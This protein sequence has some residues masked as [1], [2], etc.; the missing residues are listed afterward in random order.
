MDMIPFDPDRPVYCVGGGP[1]LD[2]FNFSMLEDKQV[3]V[4]N[5][6]YRTVKHAH[7]LFFMDQSFY[8][9]HGNSLWRFQGKHIVTTLPL[10]ELA[11]RHRDP[12]IVSIAPSTKTI[13][14]SSNSGLHAIYLAIMLQARDII[15]MGYD[16]GYSPQGRQNWYRPRKVSAEQKEK[17]AIYNRMQEAFKGAAKQFK[18]QGITIRHATDGTSQFD[19]FKAITLDQAFSSSL[20]T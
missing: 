15:L 14:P 17:W 20:T 13:G 8:Q 18:K 9:E 6:G 12:R 10:A 11:E 16:G 5:A 1:S 3:I 2:G 4:T 19:C 7:A